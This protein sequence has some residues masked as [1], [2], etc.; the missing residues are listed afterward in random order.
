M[1]VS[2]ITAAVLSALSA[3]GVQAL[4]TEAD[5][6]A[7][8]NA[9]SGVN[10]SCWTFAQAAAA[11]HSKAASLD[12]Y[13]FMVRATCDTA[14]KVAN[15]EAKRWT[16]LA[17]ACS[18]VVTAASLGVPVEGATKATVSKGI[19]A[20]KAAL[21]TTARAA[22]FEANPSAKAALAP[23]ALIAQQAAEMAQLRAENVALKAAAEQREA[24]SA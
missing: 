21:M 3:V 19:K 14:R 23:E 15:P 8:K 24:Q 13:L 4:S 1:Q 22:F 5:T 11:E 9:Q 17:S 6:A 10:D 2:T 16:A 20:A 18:T 12:A 7:A